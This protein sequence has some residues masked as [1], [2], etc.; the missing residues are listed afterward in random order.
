MFW[1]TDA[2]MVRED[3]ERWEGERDWG[4]R[5]E[6]LKAS[7]KNQKIINKEPKKSHK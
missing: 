3:M 2:A 1:R 7:I 4:A 5:C 6:T